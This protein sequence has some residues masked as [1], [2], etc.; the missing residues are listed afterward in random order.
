MNPCV[1][2]NKTFATPS[3]LKRHIHAK[4]PDGLDR[5]RETD[6]LHRCHHCHLSF[7]RSES[8]RRHIRSKHDR[9]LTL[10]S[11][12]LKQFRADYVP[13]HR[14]RCA[15]RYLKRLQQHAELNDSVGA[16]ESK[17]A[18]RPVQLDPQVSLEQNVLHLKDHGPSRPRP[19]DHTL[20]ILHEH[21]F[22]DRLTADAV[23][24][25]LLSFE[26][27][28]DIES[29]KKLLAA[30]LRLRLPFDSQGIRSRKPLA[31]FDDLTS[32]ASSVDNFMRSHASVTA[33][34]EFVTTIL[35]LARSA[36]LA[37]VLEPPVGRGASFDTLDNGNQTTPTD[38]T[39]PSS[40]DTVL[41]APVREAES[42]LGYRFAMASLGGKRDLMMALVK[43]GAD[44]NED[45]DGI[46][47]LGRAIHEGNLTEVRFILLLGANPNV[48]SSS[49]MSSMFC[50]FQYCDHQNLDS[51]V[52]EQIALVL[53]K[54]GA[55]VRCRDNSGRTPFHLA[56]RKGYTRL[57]RAMLKRGTSPDILDVTDDKHWTALHYAVRHSE[58]RCT[59]RELTTVPTPM[60]T[61]AEAIA[62]IDASS[63]ALDPIAYDS[64]E[65]LVKLLLEAG[66]SIN[67]LHNCSRSAL[68]LAVSEG[69]D[70]V[71]RLLI[72][73]GADVDLRDAFGFSALTTAA[74]D[75]HIRIVQLLLDAG[76]P[77]GTR[78]MSG[79]SA[80]MLA[81]K[82]GRT[83]IVRL[84]LDAGA[85]VH[86][87]TANGNTAMR[88]ALD[89]AWM[90]I[91][92]VDA[93][94]T[95]GE[96][97]GS[98]A[99]TSDRTEIAHLLH[100]AGAKIETRMMS[101]TMR[102]FVKTILGASGKG[103]AEAYRRS[104]RLTH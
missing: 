13:H 25:A 49:M 29:Y 33:T 66:A 63:V 98:F 34:D 94:D 48:F 92:H 67:T 23:T 90:E 104:Q 1:H 71:V 15:K 16:A 72:D 64:C 38:D 60:E 54:H 27:S 42:D 7:T 18:P 40:L 86:A 28:D 74:M 95:N 36:G 6:K 84:L 47:A 14:P 68:T 65:T 88:Y 12:C 59:H 77:L 30:V 61:E 91:T 55:D 31:H 11:F 58:K 62:Q 9:D 45:F 32:L 2:C 19:Q 82:Y 3:S 89:G 44:V 57:L 24:C 4:H 100:N 99:V 93:R 26:Q 103:R 80:L 85:D 5:S 56:A 51:C 69:K 53:L 87:Q 46:T 75:G 70:R 96:E 83:K 78:T 79:Q 41:V 35:H 37:E 17:S 21:T 39:S 73:A 101:K 102:T 52:H 43:Q 8:L 97:L 76:T 20:R 22:D 10:C 81:A 50:V